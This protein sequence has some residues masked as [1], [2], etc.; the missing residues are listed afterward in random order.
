MF[1]SKTGAGIIIKNE[2]DLKNILKYILSDNGCL[3]KMKEAARTI[4]R[5]E[6]AMDVAHSLIK[7][8]SM[9]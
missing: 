4:K 7:N 1:L 5:P 3:K 9:S 8:I 2:G 6:A